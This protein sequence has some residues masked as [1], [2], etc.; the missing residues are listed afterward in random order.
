MNITTVVNILTGVFEAIIVFMFINTYA[1]VKKERPA[2]AYAAAIA[3]LALMINISNLIV[4]YTMLNVYLFGLSIFVTAFLYNGRVVINI[5]LSV[6]SLL[7]L[8]SCEISVMFLITIIAK[9]SVEEATMAE[10]YRIL[11]IVLSKLFAFVIFKFICLRHKKNSVVT[12]RLSYWLLFLT[13]FATTVITLFIIFKLQYESAYNDLYNLS[14]FCSFGLLYSSFFSLYLYE[15]LIRQAEKD[16]NYELYK[17]QIKAQSKH[18]D[19]ILITQKEL[20]RLRHDLINHNISIK[21]FFENG[22]CSEGLE[23]MKNF[24]KTAMLSSDG[25]NTGNAA[26]D[27]II[28]TKKSIALSKGIEF[29]SNIQVPEKLFVD[30][31]DV[32]IIFGNALD[33]CIEACNR[34]NNKNKK[35]DMSVIYDDDSVICKI[36]NTSPDTSAKFLQTVKKDKKNHG[37]GIENIKSS[38]SKYKNICRFIQSDNEFTLF[39]IIFKN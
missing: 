19:E 9:V 28:N 33:N 22:D 21:A 25:I 11:G 30:A 20:K 12:L 10:N 26:L 3:A 17:Q 7:I 32:C 27:A 18:L 35:I 34:M 15:S 1:D 36:V 38:L 23:Y 2:Y 5:M 4:G 29:E 39:F 37:F 16:R 24:E 8:S 13:M 6:I 14:V 31:I